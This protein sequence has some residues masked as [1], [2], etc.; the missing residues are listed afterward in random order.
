MHHALLLLLLLTIIILLHF[1][2]F[3][4]SFIHHFYYIHYLSHLFTDLPPF[5][6]PF[7]PFIKIIQDQLV[8][9][10]YDLG[11]EVS[12]WRMVNLAGPLLL[13]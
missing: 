8:V 4:E 5:S 9:S 10:K 12:H 7:H 2:W 3:F 11:H 13:E 1:H 6:I